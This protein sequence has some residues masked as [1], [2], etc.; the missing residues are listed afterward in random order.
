MLALADGGC[1]PLDRT[2]ADI[3]AREDA[4]HAVSSRYGSRSSGQAPAALSVRPGEHV[5]AAVERDLRRQPPG[6]GVGT[7]EDEE[8]AGVEP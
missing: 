1:D 5:A 8:P 7:D 3:A 4:G 2:G 6:L